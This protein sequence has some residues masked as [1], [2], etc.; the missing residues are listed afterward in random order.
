MPVVD[1]KA[2]LDYLKY[3]ILKKL[4]M[5]TRSPEI[6]HRAGLLSMDFCFGGSR[7]PLDEQLVKLLRSTGKEELV[8]KEV[9]R[10][11]TKS[12]PKA[13]VI[14][15]EAYNL[16][17]D[18]RPEISLIMSSFEI[19]REFIV[20]KLAEIDVEPRLRINVATAT[21][22]SIS[23]LIMR[24]HNP[25]LTEKIMEER[26]MQAL[27]DRDEE[28]ATA[29]T[30][31]IIHSMTSGD[32]DNGWSLILNRVFSVDFPGGDQ[33]TEF[34]VQRATKAINYGLRDMFE[35]QKTTVWITPREVFTRSLESALG[36]YLKEIA[37]NAIII[38]LDKKMAIRAQKREKESLALEAEQLKEIREFRELEERMVRDSRLKAQ[39]TRVF[40]LK[41]GKRRKVRERRVWE[42][43]KEDTINDLMLFN[44][45]IVSKGREPFMVPE[46]QLDTS[47]R[48]A[49][50]AM[51]L[52]Q[53]VL[54]DFTK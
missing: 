20:D 32:F 44:N 28:K 8:L 17:L 34:C 35:K 45:Y 43:N 54:K 5:V 23:I 14:V 50:W 6:I 52:A 2:V 37:E 29:I 4:M 36:L 16:E 13:K 1:P 12:L 9:A 18:S 39:F 27:E 24:H 49:Q 30:A 7:A 21:M 3:K 26:V 42:L 41:K 48:R 46:G 53:K 51:F 40:G 33:Y 19:T 31:H 47:R 22:K 11:I 15:N 38:A 25:G 10:E